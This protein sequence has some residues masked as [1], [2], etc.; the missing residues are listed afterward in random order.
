MVWLPPI[1]WPALDLMSLSE[2]YSAFNIP[3]M[4]SGSVFGTPGYMCVSELL[5]L[6]QSGW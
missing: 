4:D 1:I 6:E 3:I 2:P 5:R